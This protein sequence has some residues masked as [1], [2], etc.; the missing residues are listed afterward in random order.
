MSKYS[1]VSNVCC[2]NW[3]NHLI[4]RFLKKFLTVGKTLHILLID[5]LTFTLTLIF[6]NEYYSTLSIFY[7][8]KQF[9]MKKLKLLC[10]LFSFGTL[11]C[12]AQSSVTDAYARLIPKN[13][14]SISD[15]VFTVEVSDT[16]TTSTIEVKLGTSDGLSDLV[17]YV[18]TYDVNT[19]LPSGYSFSRIGK[20]CTL[21]VGSFQDVNTLFGQVR[22]QR[23]NGSWSSPYKFVAN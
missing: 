1:R 11:T 14:P 20:I 12:L 10:L 13:N 6:L 21:E 5:T 22:I 4:I 8:P 23:S 7:N 9:S 2:P 3:I 19:G 18:F 16:S 17:N 15:G